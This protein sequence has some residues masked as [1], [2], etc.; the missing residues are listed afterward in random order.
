MN[1][2][3]L[4]PNLR[5]PIIKHHVRRCSRTTHNLIPA[6]QSRHNVAKIHL[7]CLCCAPGRPR[8]IPTRH[9]WVLSG[10]TYGRIRA[11][12]ASSAVCSIDVRVLPVQSVL[13]VKRTLG[14]AVAQA[15]SCIVGAKRPWPRTLSS[16]RHAPRTLLITATAAPSSKTRRHSV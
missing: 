2:G 1:S 12:L 6:A 8:L 11:G 5:R 13:M 16:T 10:C 15:A 9:L 7:V 3:A 14:D 4:A